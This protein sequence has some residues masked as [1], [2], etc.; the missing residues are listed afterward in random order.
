DGHSNGAEQIAVKA[1]DVGMDV[2]YEGI[3]LTPEH[4]AESA[5]QEGVH[6]V[7][8][9]ILSGSH[10]KLVPAVI[11]CMKQRGL[12]RIPVVLGGIIP[13][14]DTE[15]VHLAGVKKIYTPKDY[16]LN[17]IMNEIIDLVASA[18]NIE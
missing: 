16:N 12:E 4:I 7:G 9:S 14:T 8:L 2:V 15:N 3:R 13:K 17:H 5:L 10:R 6:I 18:N 1:R 11:E